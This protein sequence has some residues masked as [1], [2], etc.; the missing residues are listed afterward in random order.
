MAASGKN[1]VFKAAT[2]PAVALQQPTSFIVPRSSLFL[3][4]PGV[5]VGPEPSVNEAAATMPR[6]SSSL[7]LNPV[8]DGRVGG[9]VDD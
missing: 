3:E 7:R 4:K 8:F 6:S 9:E 5:S 2:P 1:P